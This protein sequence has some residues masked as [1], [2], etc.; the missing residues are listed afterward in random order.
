MGEV[1]LNF[2][3]ALRAVIPMVEKAGV[4]WKRPD[5]YDEW[6]SVATALFESLVV[7]ALRWSLPE[8]EQ[9]DFELPEYDLLRSSY[10]GLS[11]V[12]VETVEVRHLSADGE[13]IGDVLRECPVEGVQFSLRQAKPAMNPP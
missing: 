6:D 13:P 12:E 1:I 10:Q 4:P 5:A 8:D 3:A 7:A 2:R 9:E 11:A